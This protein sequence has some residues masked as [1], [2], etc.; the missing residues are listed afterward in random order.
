M[1][2]LY[3]LKKCKGL[4]LPEGFSAKLASFYPRF[5]MRPFPPY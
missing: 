1:R 2:I 4:A 5:T 3:Y